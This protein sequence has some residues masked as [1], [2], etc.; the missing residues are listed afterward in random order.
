MNKKILELRVQLDNIDKNILQLLEERMDIIHQVGCMK[1]KLNI[2]IEDIDREEKI[3]NKLKNLSKNNLTEN[4]L[5]N[6][7]KIIFNFSKIEQN[8]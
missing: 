4:Q 7:F 5:K 6:L 8:N 1:Y 2:P 3:I